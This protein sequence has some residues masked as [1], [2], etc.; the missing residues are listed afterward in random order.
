[1]PSDLSSVL[2]LAVADVEQRGNAVNLD[3]QT[4]CNEVVV[5]AQGSQGEP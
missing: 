5:G 3:A 1:V 2:Q 4:L